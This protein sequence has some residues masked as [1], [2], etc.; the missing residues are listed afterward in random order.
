MMISSSVVSINVRRES[1]V[2]QTHE[3]RGCL[4]KNREDDGSG[5]EAEGVVVTLEK[6]GDSNWDVD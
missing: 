2:G 1:D 5:L 4:N 6:E 3:I